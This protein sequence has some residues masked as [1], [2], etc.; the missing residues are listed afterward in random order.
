[1]NSVFK[2]ILACVLAACTITVARQQPSSRAQ[3]NAVL[4]STMKQELDRATGELKKHDPAPYFL[5]Y[6]VYDQQ[7]AL[8]VAAQG[9]LITSTRLRHRAADVIMRVGAP[10]LDNTHEEN[11]VSALSSGA[12]PLA[13]DPDAMLACCGG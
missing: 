9:S 1:M 10:A 11:R 4:L 6:S 7:V 5:S 3:M 2:R 13:D 8:A 12:L